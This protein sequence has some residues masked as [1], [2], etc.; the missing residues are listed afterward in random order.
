MTRFDR[1]LI[2]IKNHKYLSGA[3]LVGTIVSTL[4]TFSNT[5]IDLWDRIV[6]P[7]PPGLSVRFSAPRL[8]ADS[9]EV[10]LLVTNT[11]GDP[12]QLTALTILH[13]RTSH[14][15]WAGFRMQ[16]DTLLI[17][18]HATVSA[19][20]AE[21]AWYLLGA[22]YCGDTVHFAVQFEVLDP[23][24][25]SRTIG[26]LEIAYA[27]GTAHQGDALFY[28][29]RELVVSA[30]KGRVDQVRL[31]G[32]LL[33]FSSGATALFTDT[34]VRMRALLDSARRHC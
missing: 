10:P 17:Y 29:Y 18:A 11:A 26:P 28:D 30:F 3:L 24:L 16:S 1:S 25:G 27:P 22:M 32:G 8:F 9:I 4:A 20:V 21:S 14:P 7:S 5:L 2:W 13:S 15:G 34:S 6:K 19:K 31:G 23:S 12:W 33:A